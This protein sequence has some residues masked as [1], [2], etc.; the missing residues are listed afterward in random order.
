VVDVLTG[1]FKF[2]QAAERKA[3][4]E[5]I[6]NW[7]LECVDNVPTLTGVVLR[8]GDKLRVLRLIDSACEPWNG[9]SRIENR[10]MKQDAENNRA[11][12]PFAWLASTLTVNGEHRS[13]RLLI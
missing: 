9:E 7:K 6:I 8:D 10:E 12:D 2:S 5:E 11:A 13:G 4:A 3:R 1:I